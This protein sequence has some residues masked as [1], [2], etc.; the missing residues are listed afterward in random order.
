MVAGF[1]FLVICLCVFPAVEIAY[2]VHYLN[3]PLCSESRVVSPPVW[4]I[5]DGVCSFLEIANLAVMMAVACFANRVG[6]SGV[7][8]CNIC[9]LLVT[10]VF[11][12]L[13]VI[14]GSVAFFRDNVDCSPDDLSNMMYTA[15]IIG[16]INA[17]VVLVR[18][19]KSTEDRR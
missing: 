13:W 11:K 6:L 19:F 9:L 3:T 14:V 12:F 18:I 15:L 10:G 17:F 16:Y 4:L 1:G 8:C 5:I 7:A 2:G